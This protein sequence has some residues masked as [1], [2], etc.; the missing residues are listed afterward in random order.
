[1]WF[2][3]KSIGSSSPPERVH[4]S[5]SYLCPVAI[6][7]AMSRGCNL[8]SVG[9][10]AVNLTMQGQHALAVTQASMDRSSLGLQINFNYAA[11]VLLSLSFFLLI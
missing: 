9:K 8:S 10:L 3:R 5:N 11:L 7:S 1:M 2:E 6:S 4:N